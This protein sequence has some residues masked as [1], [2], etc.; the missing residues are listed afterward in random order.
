MK[1]RW[2][3]VSSFLRQCQKDVYKSIFTQ[4]DDTKKLHKWILPPSFSSCSLQIVSPSRLNRMEF[5]KNWACGAFNPDNINWQS[6]SPFVWTSG[7][8]SPSKIRS[9]PRRESMDRVQKEV[10]GLGPQWWPM[11][12][13]SMFCIRPFQKYT[14]S[15][16]RVK[17]K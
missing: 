6:Y 2:L 11:D 17:K 12:R 1:W 15:W 10:H 14:P 3:Q 13:G 8:N 16:T 9:G 7:K 5:R 4:L